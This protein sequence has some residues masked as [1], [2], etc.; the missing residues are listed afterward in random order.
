[1][2]LLE[3]YKELYYK[4]LEHSDRLN[5][6]ISVSLTLLTIIGG[7]IIFLFQECVTHFSTSWHSII[8]SVLSLISIFKFIQC[9]YRFFKAYSGYIYSYFPVKGA[10]NNIDI[11]L[12]RTAEIENGDKIAD[13]HIEAMMKR[14]FIEGALHNNGMNALKHKRHRELGDCIIFT[15]IIVVVTYLFCVV[16][17]NFIF[18]SAQTKLSTE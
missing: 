10:K 6:K 18:V 15:F 2:N 7:G 17:T 12:E 4:E 8:L 3:E 11:L 1:M 9:I 13:H 16:S 5:S 14:R